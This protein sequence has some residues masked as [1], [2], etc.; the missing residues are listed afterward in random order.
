MAAGK[1]SAIFLD[2]HRM[3]NAKFNVAGLGRLIFNGNT[4]IENRGN[5][6]DVLKRVPNENE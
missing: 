2:I 4:V 5:E 1:C 3:K 6:C